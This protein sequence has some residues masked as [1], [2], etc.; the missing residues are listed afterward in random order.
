MSKSDVTE[1]VEQIEGADP[2]SVTHYQNGGGHFVIEADADDVDFEAVGEALIDAGVEQAGGL[3]VP[4]MVQIN[5]E[6]A[7]GDGDE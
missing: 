3:E 2:D 1:A 5:Y 4:G 6:T 7:G